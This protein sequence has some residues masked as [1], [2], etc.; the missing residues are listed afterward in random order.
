MSTLKI[1]GIFPAMA[2]PF[3]SDG[4]VWKAK[5][6]YNVSKWN[7]TDLAGYVVCGST[8]ESV[9]LDHNER[10]QF[11]E[12][13][14]EAAA[15]EKILIAGTGAESVRETLA[16]TNKAAELGYKAALVVN[17]HYYK[18]QL[19][20][21]RAQ[22]AFYGAVADGAK[23]PV[24]LYNLPQNTGIELATD[25]V[26][27]LSHHPNIIGM[28]DS[29]GN[30]GRMIRMLGEVKPG[31]Q[32]LTGH[33]GT[34]APALSVGAVGAVLAFANAAPYACISIWEAHRTREADAAM[35]WQRRIQKPAT[36]IA[37]KYGIGGLKYA[38]DVMGYFG[39][40]P[41]LPL[42]PPSPEAKKDIEAAFADLRG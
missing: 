10:F 40:M 24:L 42:L 26:A 6:E 20:G 38:M 3:N 35:D 30:V 9:L 25:A 16:L 36:L 18:G 28:K 33:A 4:D 12:W 34:L 14:A 15:P 37:E 2:T 19:S 1:N 5:V 29:S 22:Q 31:F 39:G 23:I 8:G 41:R 7:K 11:W 17:P 13:V 27:E 21:A 32:M